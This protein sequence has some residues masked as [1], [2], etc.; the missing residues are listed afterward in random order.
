MSASTWFDDLPVIGYMSPAEAATKLREVGDNESAAALE[1]AQEA[2]DILS[3]VR[4]ESSPVLEKYPS[5]TAARQSKWWPLL[6]K[7]WRYT[8]HTF[9]YLAPAPLD[10]DQL[11]ILPIDKIS[12]DSRLKDSRVKI[13]LDHLRVASYPGRGIHHV[14]LHFAAQNQAANGAESVHFNATYRVLEGQRAAVRGYPVFTGLHV[15]REGFTFKCRTINVKNEQDE[16]ILEFLE[17]D[18][19]KAG[20]KLLNIAHPVV[21]PF[22]EMAYGLAKGVARHNRNIAVQDIDLSLDFGSNPIGVRLAEGEY[23]AIQTP[24]KQE[25]VWDWDDWIYDRA[26]GQVVNKANRR[27]LI[28][29]N[30]LV[31][32][33]SRY[34]GA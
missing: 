22:S 21:A 25:L 12:A 26:S 13:T 9:G 30:Y 20:L 3:A 8:A 10:N 11:P 18:V 7:P 6:D 32:G 14:L 2:M 19:F 33:I 15:G 1:A 16:Q 34:D 29:Y 31:F 28:P 4:Q 23:L 27:Q 24:E 17:S 5:G